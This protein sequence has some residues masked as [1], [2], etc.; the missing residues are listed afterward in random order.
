LRTCTTAPD[1]M[2]LK[3]RC[4]ALLHSQTDSAIE[5]AA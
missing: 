4:L 5:D 1:F 3:E 2:A